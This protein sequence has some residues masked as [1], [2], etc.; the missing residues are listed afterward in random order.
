[1]SVFNRIFNGNNVSGMLAVYLIDH[2]RQCG[3]FT[4]SGRAGYQY[5]AAWI[6]GEFINHLRQSQVFD[7]PDLVRYKP[8]RR[9]KI[10]PFMESVYP[11]AP[12][13][14]EGEAEVEFLITQEYLLLV[15]I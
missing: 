1:M 8:Q 10:A 7:G 3:R 14:A 11:E 4:G 5:Q 6:F 12:Q 2:R 9:G 13:I 15:I